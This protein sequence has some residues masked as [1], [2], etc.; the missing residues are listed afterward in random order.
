MSQLSIKPGVSQKMMLTLKGQNGAA[1]IYNNEQ[2]TW[3]VDGNIG[4]VSEDGTFTAGKKEG[5][6]SIKATV[7]GRQLVIP[8]TVITPKPAAVSSMDDVMQWKVQSVRASTFIR[9]LSNQLKKGGKGYIAMDYDFTKHPSAVSASY[10]VPFSK[11]TIPST[12]TSLSLWVSGDGNKNW[13]R[14]STSDCN[15]KEHVI[16]FTNE[17]GLSWKGWR[18]VTTKIPTGIQYPIRVNSIYVAQGNAKLKGKGALLFNELIA[19][20]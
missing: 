5:K 19:T 15:G 6:G 4:T 18:Q 7:A 13:L 1:L 8:V 16:N 14:A 17:Y 2:V 20:Y 9:G 12:P 11:L 3:T 10:L